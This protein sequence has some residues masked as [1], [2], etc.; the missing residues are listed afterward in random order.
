M[1]APASPRC[2]CC[3]PS[4]PRAARLLERREPVERGQPER[5][6]TISCL[7][8]G[9][10]A[11][12][13]GGGPAREQAGG[14]R[15]EELDV[16]LAVVEGEVITRRRLVREVGGLAR[17]AGPRHAGAA[18]PGRAS[19]SGPAC[20]CSPRRRSATSVVDPRRATSRTVV[21]DELEKAVARRPPR[22]IGAPVSDRGVPRGDRASRW[23]SS[24]SSR[25]EELHYQGV[26]HPLCTRASAGPRG[27]RWTWTSRR[28]RCVAST[29]AIPARSTRSRRVR[30]AVF[31]LDVEKYLVDD[32]I[33]LPRRR[34]EGAPPTPRRSR[35]CSAKGVA[36]G[37]LRRA[38]SSSAWLE[39]VQGRRRSPT[40]AAT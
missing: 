29:G 39:G 30:F 37:R 4:S 10:R 11:H 2:S 6:P 3:C 28:P 12:A 14:A 34:G 26:R 8:P 22:R 32:D 17:R 1:V 9:Y 33:G 25:S 15:G 31:H 19:S 16:K 18:D 5:E 20:S 35:A 21:D 36:G 24:A 27:R 23:R 7:P 38:A 40:R 13:G